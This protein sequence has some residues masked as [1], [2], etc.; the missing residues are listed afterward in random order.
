VPEA[1]YAYFAEEL[2]QGA[3]ADL[4]WHLSQ[5]ALSS[6]VTTVLAESLLGDDAERAVRD[7]RRLGFIISSE[8]DGYEMHPLLRSFMEGKFR[9]LAGDRAPE[10]VE[11]LVRIHIREHGWDD[12]FS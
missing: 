9:E 7:G 3:D 10:I 11:Q 5:L 4:R 8:Q 12:A 2:Y 6:T 1:L